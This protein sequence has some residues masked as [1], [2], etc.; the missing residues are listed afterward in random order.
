MGSKPTEAPAKVTD[1][2]AGTNVPAGPTRGAEEAAKRTVERLNDDIVDPVVFGPHSGK[3]L[4][5]LPKEKDSPK[6]EDLR[7]MVVFKKDLNYLATISNRR[8][9]AE[10]KKQGFKVWKKEK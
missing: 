3:Y 4:I 6:D 10:M 5:R 2:P 7:L 8:L 9:I 1:E